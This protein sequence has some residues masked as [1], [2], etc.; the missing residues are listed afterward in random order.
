LHQ[1]GVTSSQAKALAKVAGDTAGKLGDRKAAKA[2]DKYRKTLV[3]LRDALLKRDQERINELTDQKD[4]LEDSESPELNDDVEV[5][6]E[7]RKQTPNFVRLLGPRQVLSYLALYEDEL[8]DPLASLQGALDKSRTAT[9]AEWKE[10]RE[11]TVEQVGWQVAGLDT[12]A[13]A[14]VSGKVGEFLDRVKALKDD[15]FKAQRADLEK[16]AREIVGDLAPTD[17]L[18]HVL[19]HDVA[20]LLSNP[21]LPDV[22]AAWMKDSKK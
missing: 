10:L 8:P 21:R 3:D 14:K 22:L 2:S 5:T 20:E 11:E 7:A 4:D 19:E 16:A 17:V 18:R 12:A 6:G 9:A 15:D 13:V 1:L